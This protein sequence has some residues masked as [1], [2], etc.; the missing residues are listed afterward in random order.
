MIICRL[1]VGGT[2]S[3]ILGR[4]YNITHHDTTHDMPDTGT[5]I[6]LNHATANTH[7]FYPPWSGAAATSGGQQS[8]YLKITTQTLWS[9]L[10]LTQARIDRQHRL[11]FLNFNI[12]A[13]QN[14]A[15]RSYSMAILQSSRQYQPLC[16][17]PLLKLSHFTTETTSLIA[18]I[19]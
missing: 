14:A 3:M 11:A 7:A 18:T 19:A 10:V 8:I 12:I 17:K 6:S 15:P 13:F 2:L 16:R 1:M 5:W 4:H 9:R